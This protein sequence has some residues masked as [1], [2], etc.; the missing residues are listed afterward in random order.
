M[1]TLRKC[2]SE[3]NQHLID[4]ENCLQSN[5]LECDLEF[6]NK[7]EKLLER[8]INRLIRSCADATLRYEEQC[9]DNNIRMQERGSQSLKKYVVRSRKL[10][11]EYRLK[12]N[13]VKQEDTKKKLLHVQTPKTQNDMERSEDPIRFL[14][15]LH[16]T[17]QVMSDEIQRVT[18]VSKLMDDGREALA[19]SH[20]EYSS[21]K[22][23][24]QAI[25][26]QLM[27][28][29]WQTKKD[30]LWIGSGILTLL[31]TLIVIIHQRFLKFVNSSPSPFHAVQEAIEILKSAG[32]QAIAEDK[33]HQNDLQPGG[34]Y[35]VTRNRSAIIAFAIGGKH[36]RRNGFNII[37]AHTDSPC[38]KI[39]PISNLES[40][41]FL[42]VGVECYGGGLF[43]TWF[44]RDLGFAGRVIVRES[45]RSFKT[46][47]VCVN[48]PIM[49]IPTLA[50]HLDREAANGINYNKETHLRPILATAIRAELEKI[51]HGEK[52]AKKDDERPKHHS[53]LLN[54]IAKELKVRTEEV[55]DFELCLFDTQGANVGGLLN[56]FI[57][58]ARLDN[59]CCSWLALKSL[60]SSIDSLDQETNTR[61]IALF[62]NE[63]VG[64]Q[65][66]MG[67]GSDFLQTVMTAVAGEQNWFEA[68][69]NSFCV[70][71]DMAHGV[72]PN[73]SQKHE[74]NHRPALHAGPVIK[75][76]ANQR[77]ATT[78]E[79]AF[80]MKELARR[81]GVKLQEFVVR[82]D[83]GCGSTIGPIMS[84]NTGMRTI[85]VGLAQL[86]MHSIREMCGTDDLE[87]GLTWFKAFF[88]EFTN[89]NS[90]LS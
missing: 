73:Y 74:H 37:G 4:L 81:H 32:F 23:E 41:G 58:S 11:M 79:S 72:H 78:S 12:S 67:A 86:S 26:K 16:R 31:T 52:K 89:L 7:E 56:E 25:R 77:Y 57:F 39:K 10:L 83:T 70:S 19:S 46:R 65:S 55:C 18:N 75:Y 36:E 50:I 76:N 88:S 90:Y 51:A 44:D 45:K 42:Q 68:A 14:A 13:A 66:R 38:L 30:R 64:S 1:E 33:L 21:V 22:N 84:T 9:K 61:M 63:E 85:D 59:L 54:L 87:L 20:Q 17:R 71:A 8:E 6:T 29:Q 35:Y 69:R 28:L 2:E 15:S 49:R 24:I 60:V 43:H 80:L 53:I 82:Q 40:E 48:R 27:H 34:K 3:L 62:D 47:L 5:E